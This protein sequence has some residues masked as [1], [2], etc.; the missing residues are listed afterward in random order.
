VN[1]ATSLGGAFA[2]GV[3]VGEYKSIA[4]AAKGLVR[5]DKSYTPERQNRA[6]Y[7]EVASRWQAAYAAQLKL[8]D[9]GVTKS[10]WKAPGLQI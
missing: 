1:E 10:M 5:W 2:C 4:E 7:Q 8:V 9:E 6:K 3:A